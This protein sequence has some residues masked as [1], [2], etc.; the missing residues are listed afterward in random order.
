MSFEIQGQKIPLPNR[1]TDF[2]SLQAYLLHVKKVCNDKLTEI[3][4]N[5]P[6]RN[7]QVSSKK[8]KTMSNHEEEIDDVDA[9]EDDE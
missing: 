1:S 8:Q 9:E 6:D 4:E 3:I 5:H 2:P 7:P